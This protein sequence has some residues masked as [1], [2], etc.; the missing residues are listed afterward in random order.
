[1]ATPL[2][3]EPALNAPPP[4]TIQ[5]TPELEPSFATVAVNTCVAPPIMAAGLVGA[6]VIETGFSVIVAVVDLVGSLM[7][8]AV[9]VT[10]VTALI[11]VVGEL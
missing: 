7:L 11:T 3:V 10:V 1:V 5:V 8:V 2:N 9:S 4:V 6:I